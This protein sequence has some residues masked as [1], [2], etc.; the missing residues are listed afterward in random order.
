MLVLLSLTACVDY[1]LNGEKLATEPPAS[2]PDDVGPLVEEEVPLPTCDPPDL[3]PIEVS[4]DESCAVIGD[5]FTPEVR[6]ADPTVGYSYTTPV[7]GYLTSDDIPDIVVAD[8]NG[9]VICLSGDGAGIHWSTATYRGLGGTPAIADLDGDGQAEV[10]YPASGG[11][12]AFDGATGTQLWFTSTL[13]VPQNDLC[14]AVGVFDLDADGSPE[15]VFGRVVLNADG[16]PRFSTK[17]DGAPHAMGVAA[18]I[19]RDGR[20]ELLYGGSVYDAEGEL[21]WDN[22]GSGG[23]VAVGNFDSDA[24]AEVVVSAD[25]RLRL[26]DTDGSILWEHSLEAGHS[27][28][29]VVVDADGDG[30]PEI[31]VPT[32]LMYHVFDG[33]G[34]ELWRT[35]IH[36]STSGMTGSVAFDF[37]SDGLPE[38]VF[39]DEEDLI[40]FDALT[41]VVRLRDPE[42]ASG[43]CTETPVVV[44][45][46][47]DG[48][49]EI[50]HVSS[51]A[52]GPELGLRVLGSPHWPGTRSVWNQHAYAR[53][54]VNDDL[55]VPPVP[56]ASWL[57]HNTFRVPEALPMDPGEETLLTDASIH[58]GEV[59]ELECDQDRLR[60]V[61]R[62]GNTG[63]QTLPA[64]L[65]LRLVTESGSTVSETLGADL[66][67]G[68]TSQG[69]VFDLEPTHGDL[70]FHV[71]PDGSLSECSLENNEIT[72][73]APCP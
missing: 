24:E 69:F 62:I 8:N 4:I 36:E 60:V 13:E 58:V 64:G 30:R 43:T 38:I 50:V 14:G 63:L 54:N 48:R 67:P 68:E 10:I 66:A 70:V 5:P 41:G 45:A 44:D 1:E 29:P 25:G 55:T 17:G 72:V 56:D 3:S 37:E 53:S 28:S 6:W 21:V 47:G 49:A 57:D 40:I 20:Q 9:R 23:H 19:D 27:G 7:V 32:D 46:D 33:E 51:G 11:V 59:C 35:P 16:S 18:D 2:E 61:M 42:H 31:G 15:I 26:E 71:D 52:F 34:N 22:G 65:E 73:A 39:A 12:Y